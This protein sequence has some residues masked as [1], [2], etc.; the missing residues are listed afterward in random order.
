M[1]LTPVLLPLSLLASGVALATPHPAADGEPAA[2][3]GPR[4]TEWRGAD[5]TGAAHDEEPPVEWS[6]EKNIRWKQELPGRGHST[7]V[8]WGDRLYVTTAIETDRE[9]EGAGEGEP[10]PEGRSGRRG[11]RGGGWG[12]KPAPTKFHEFVVLCLDRG[13]GEEV[14]RRT[15]TEAV[16]HEGGHSDSTFA[17]NSPLTDGERIYASFG[18]RGIHCLDMK[19]EVQ[20]SKDFGLMRTAMQFGEGSSPALHGDSLV[21]T[22]DHEGDSFIVALDRKS[23]EEQWRSER[24]EGTTWAT[25]LIIEVDGSPQVIVPGTGMSRGYDLKS[26]EVIWTCG[27]MTRNCIPSPNHADGVVYLMS[28]FRGAALQ[29]IQLEGAEGDLIG[30]EQVK[31]TH[32]RNTS[33]VPSA[34][35]YDGLIYFLSGNSGSLSCMDA[36]TGEILYEDQRLDGVRAVYSSPVGANGRVYITSRK[37][38]TKVIAHGREYEEL[39]TNQLD[40]GVDAS[41]V[42]VDDEIYLRGAKNLYCIAEGRQAH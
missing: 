1:K 24:D 21:V 42:L 17:S 33:Y 14:W 30:T 11:G 29:A 18:S 8:V 9:V 36:E 15:V 5:G 37:G 28:G 3:D 32:D 25:P 4:W 27:G 2:A 12:S 19:G 38:L 16:P 7:P 13:D 31:W 40:D 23:G 34:L 39:A 20:W 10:E 35:L 41:A 22:W 26:G 6:E